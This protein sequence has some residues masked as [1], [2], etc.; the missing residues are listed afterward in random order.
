MV[1][2]A[3]G[4][5]KSGSPSDFVRFSLSPLR[6]SAV[7]S[8][9]TNLP[10]PGDGTA[11]GGGSVGGGAVP[12]AGDAAMVPGNAAGVSEPWENTLESEAE[13]I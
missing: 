3:L 4:E 6:I 2:L 10:L 9:V 13:W 11:L 1:V 8:D 12:S 5:G 7:T